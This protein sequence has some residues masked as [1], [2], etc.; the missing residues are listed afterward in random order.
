MKQIS[1]EE[2]INSINRI[3]QWRLDNPNGDLYY[4]IGEEFRTMFQDCH[5]EELESRAKIESDIASLYRDERDLLRTEKE[6]CKHEDI[7]VSMWNGIP[8]RKIVTDD[9][10]CGEL[11]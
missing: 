6:K 8:I 3:D 7:S 11:Q 9:G 1:K 5:C 2:F 4:I 10:I